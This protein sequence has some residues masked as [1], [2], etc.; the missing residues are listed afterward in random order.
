MFCKNTIA[1]ENIYRVPY[2]GHMEDKMIDFFNLKNG[3]KRL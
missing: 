3:A 1:K 2:T